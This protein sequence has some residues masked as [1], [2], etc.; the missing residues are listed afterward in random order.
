MPQCAQCTSQ[1]SSTFANRRLHPARHQHQILTGT[2]LLKYHPTLDYTII[3]IKSPILSDTKKSKKKNQGSTKTSDIH[4][5][6]LCFTH[7]LCSHHGNGR[8]TGT[9][10]ADPMTHGV[11]VSGDFAAHIPSLQLQLPL[12]MITSSSSSSSSS[13]KF[14]VSISI[15]WLK[16]CQKNLQNHHE[17]VVYVYTHIYIYTYVYPI[18]YSHQ[19]VGMQFTLL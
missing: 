11:I 12:K 3:I 13:S 8:L 1:S 19:M 7:H 4:P 16:Q 14:L 6:S 10:Q 17:W 9:P 5:T 2:S 15:M 18:R